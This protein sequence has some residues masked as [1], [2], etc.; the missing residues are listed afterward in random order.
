MRSRTASSFDKHAAAVSS[1]TH[2]PG[3]AVANRRNGP[4]RRLHHRRVK[5]ELSQR[6]APMMTINKLQHVTYR[7]ISSWASCQCSGRSDARP[8]LTSLHWL[9]IHEHIAYKVARCNIR[10][11]STKSYR[12]DLLQPVTASRS[13]LSVDSV[14]LQIL[15]T[16][17]ELGRRAL[18]VAAPTVWNSLLVQDSSVPYLYAR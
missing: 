18:S 2:T 14:R 3:P 16:R 1:A 5:I 15:R 12:S 8:L 9:P 7:T 6:C 4:H 17:T 13:S 10:T 11:S